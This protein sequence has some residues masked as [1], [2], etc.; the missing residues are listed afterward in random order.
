[1]AKTLSRTKPCS[2]ATRSGRMAK[3]RQFWDSAE[4]LDAL[5]GD[6]D[7]L[8]DAHITLCVHA[9]I[10]A[11]DVICCA[12]LGDLADSESSPSG[13]SGALGSHS[14]SRRCRAFVLL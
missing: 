4:L 7:D 2:A 9:G 14:G 8:C 3:A 5:E 13:H 11:A 6:E 1:M 12:R 10:G